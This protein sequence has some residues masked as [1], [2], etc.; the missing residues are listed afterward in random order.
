MRNWAFVAAIVSFLLSFSIV[1]GI[2]LPTTSITPSS[3][4]SVSGVPSISLPFLSL[5]SY[6]VYALLL[7]LAVAIISSAALKLTQLRGGANSIGFIFGLIM[8]VYLYLNPSIAD[9]LGNV[10]VIYFAAALVLAAIFASMRRGINAAFAAISLLIIFLLAFLIIANNK[11]L[12]QE[13]NNM[14]HINVLTLLSLALP[15]IFG[16]IFLYIEYKVF[17]RIGHKF[18]GGLI[19]LLTALTFFVPGF[20]FFLWLLIPI[21]IAVLIIYIWL[22]LR[23]IESPEEKRKEKRPKEKKPKEEKR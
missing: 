11:P 6:V 4:G 3:V 17:S 18:I 9:L 2:N 14:F 12:Q 23:G 1:F 16:L 22:W 13:L 19:M 5:P 8:F 20:I 10:M 7:S 21:L 15:Y